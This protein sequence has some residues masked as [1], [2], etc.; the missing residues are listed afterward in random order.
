MDSTRAVESD[1]MATLTQPPAPVAPPPPSPQP[2][3]A[4]QRVL[5]TGIRWQTYEA[6][7]EDLGNR[8]VFLTYDRGSLE[9]MAPLFRHEGFTR[10]LGRVVEIT[11]EVL[12]IP[13]KAGWSTT[14]RR[15]D[16]ERGLEP[17]RCFYI[18]NVAAIVGKLD[19]DLTRDPPPDLAIETDITHSSLDRM[20]IYAS[21]GVPEVWRFDGQQLQVNLLQTGPA[22]RPAE[23]S[24]SFPTLPLA[25]VAGLVHQVA[26]PDDLAQMR[27]IRAWVQQHAL[28]NRP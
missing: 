13:F 17:D 16:L 20:S 3:V 10:V 11:A 23:A 1:V 12:N 7:L 24:R 27:T 2:V 14:F 26:T 15:R 5:L 9:I 25:E 4:E 21:L 18:A 22:Y 19:I 28:P 6:L 8:H